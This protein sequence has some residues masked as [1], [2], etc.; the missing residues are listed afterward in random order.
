M[1]RFFRRCDKAPERYTRI[2]DVEPEGFQRNVK[3]A[4]FN[5]RAALD[6]QGVR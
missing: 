6:A 5:L 2:F 3:S 4:R 1:S